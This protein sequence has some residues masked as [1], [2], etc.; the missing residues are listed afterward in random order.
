MRNG[1]C[2]LISTQ[3]MENSIFNNLSLTAKITEI[4]LLFNTQILEDKILIIVEGVFDKV[5][6]FLFNNEKVFIKPNN[7][8]GGL[9]N[10]LDE[11]NKEYKDFLIIIK[12]ADFDH[13]NKVSYEQYN[14]LFLTDT[15]DIETMMLSDPNIEQRLSEKFLSRKE[16]GFIQE[17]M[18]QLEFLSYLK[19]YNV[20]NHL[21]LIVKQIKIGNVYDG[22]HPVS[23][24]D[25]RKEL[26]KNDKNFKLC[27]DIID[28][29]QAFIA[30]NKTDDKWNLTNGHDLCK[31]LN[32]YFNKHG[33]TK[34][35][36]SD[37][38]SH[39]YAMADFEKTKLYSSIRKWE[40][41]HQINILKNNFE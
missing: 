6:G 36:V 40:D 38:L 2:V 41:M 35:S 8:C 10:F 11:L 14:N 34:E 24:D 13:L 12:D 19:W 17:C 27:P 25:C 32:I 29:V 31:A 5:Y 15:H 26:Y 3:A 1:I 7:T 30:L 20:K 37:Y 22:Y 16:E 21:K 33:N 23:L 18:E 9:K 4:K 39:G 28:K